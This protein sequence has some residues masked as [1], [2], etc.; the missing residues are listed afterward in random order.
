AS[1]YK[2]TTG[3]YMQALR[4]AARHGVLDAVL[5]DLAEAGRT[6]P[7]RSV[8]R[9]AAKAARFVPEFEEIAATQQAAGLPAALFQG[10]AEVYREITAGELAAADPESID[11]A[12]PAREAIRRLSQRSG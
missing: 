5:A 4:T 2:G 7:T 10:F 3:L 8:V 1:G 12:M 6:D 9:A 11:R